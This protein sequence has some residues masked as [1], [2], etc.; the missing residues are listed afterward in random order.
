MPDEYPSNSQ[1]IGKEERVKPQAARTRSAV[2]PKKVERIAQGE[3]TRR[4]KPIGKRLKEIFISGDA[5]SV[6][7]VVAGDVLIPAAKDMITD[8]ATQA[9]ERMVFG[10]SRGFRGR[11]G[12]YRPPGAPGHTSYNRYSQPTN[13][14]QWRTETPRDPSRR[15]RSTHDF[16]E[17]ILDS[18][19]E[20]ERVIDML[21]EMVSQ[22][23]QATVA[24]LYELVG[25]TSQYTDNK[26]GWTQLQ[27]AGVQHIR[28]GQF[29]LNLP[30]PEP[31][32]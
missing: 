6:L 3:V 8:A 9:V 27:G 29:L 18:R 26:Y 13:N 2:E 30:K 7:G 21:M 5:R 1:N 22:Y 32:D 15:A 4:K 17:L 10:E 16:D 19:A 23:G 12:G 25:T 20:A 14:A 11:P 24:D 28:G 31:L